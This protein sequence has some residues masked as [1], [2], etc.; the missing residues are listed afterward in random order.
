MRKQVYNNRVA[1]RFIVILVLLVCSLA[2]ITLAKGG[3]DWYHFRATHTAI[4]GTV[5]KIKP[6]AKGDPPGVGL[7]AKVHLED[8]RNVILQFLSS[9]DHLQVSQKIPL[10]LNKDD[11]S[12][13]YRN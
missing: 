5:V 11:S 7:I 10:W 9:Q 4:E 13:S 8:G 12:V 1:N 3:W 6:I 2:G